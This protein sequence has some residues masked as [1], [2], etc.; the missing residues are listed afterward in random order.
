[1]PGRSK[2]EVVEGLAKLKAAATE[3]EEALFEDAIQLISLLDGQ[4][5]EVVSAFRQ[6]VDLLIQTLP[7]SMDEEGMPLEVQ[8]R[9]QQAIQSGKE[10]GLRNRG[11]RP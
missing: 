1:M 10:Q 11:D 6:V 3:D 9:L 2:A 4:K 8:V 7:S 5:R